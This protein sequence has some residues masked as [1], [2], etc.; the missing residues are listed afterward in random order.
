MAVKTD[1]ESEKEQ[2]TNLSLRFCAMYDKTKS[3]VFA[4]AVKIDALS[5]NIILDINDFQNQRSQ[6]WNHILSNYELHLFVHLKHFFQ[7]FRENGMIY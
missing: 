4:S 5:G 7:T 2:N 1:R 6:L 3:F